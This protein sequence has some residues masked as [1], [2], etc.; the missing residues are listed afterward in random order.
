MAGHRR[1]EDPKQ[2]N[3][4]RSQ[5]NYKI[6]RLWVLLSITNLA[7]KHVHLQFSYTTTCREKKCTIGAARFYSLE[8][9]VTFAFMYFNIGIMIACSNVPWPYLLE[10]KHSVLLCSKPAI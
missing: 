2:W 7:H 3:S 9:H 5:S 1:R 10:R 4:S 8:S 6:S